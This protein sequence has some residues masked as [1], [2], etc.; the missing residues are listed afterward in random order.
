MS[1]SAQFEKTK[2]CKISTAQIPKSKAVNISQ[3]VLINE[4]TDSEENNFQSDRD[5]ILKPISQKN[6]KKLKADTP[7]YFDRDEIIEKTING[8][9]CDH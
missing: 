1:N 3:S 4:T 7:Y 8:N 2:C 9:Y 5:A 6:D